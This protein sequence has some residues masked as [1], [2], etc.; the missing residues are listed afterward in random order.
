IIGLAGWEEL[1]LLGVGLVALALEV[2]V[3]PG[4][5]IAGL[6]AMFSIGAAVFLALIGSLATWPDIARAAGIVM[7][8]IVIT[9]MTIYLV[10]RH[11]PTADRWG[12]VF[13]KAATAKAEGYI[14]AP[15][16]SDLVGLD[17]VAATDLHPSGVVIVGNER[18]DVVSEGGFVNKGSK[19]R[20]VQSDG[21][22]H[23]VRATGTDTTA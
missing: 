8:A 18:M 13:L 2:F 17:G 23:V 21:Y 12:G 7:T 6:I 20:F 3:V 16:R 4:F 22:R 19:V 5:G 15:A 10:F 9:T 1:I 14:A 11:L